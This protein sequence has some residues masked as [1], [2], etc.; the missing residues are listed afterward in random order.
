MR[1]YNTNSGEETSESVIHFLVLSFPL[2]LIADVTAH[3]RANSGKA[4]VATRHQRI[5]GKQTERG[6]SREIARIFVTRK[7]LFYPIGVFF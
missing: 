3:Q 5:A 6:R 4:A 1:V 7:K 2:R